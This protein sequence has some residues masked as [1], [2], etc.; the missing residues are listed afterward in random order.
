MKQTW[1]TSHVPNKVIASTP[2]CVLR[3]PFTMQQHAAPKSER[4][5]ERSA[6]HLI[7][8]QM[9]LMVMVTRNGLSTHLAETGSH[10]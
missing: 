1:G 4:I 7:T 6:N 5:T 2:F 3:P 8:K 9:M 10:K